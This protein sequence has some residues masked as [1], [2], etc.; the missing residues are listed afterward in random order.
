VLNP[1]N[2]D[3]GVPSIQGQKEDMRPVE[4]LV[5]WQTISS[6]KSRC[7]LIGLY[8]DIGRDQTLGFRL[9]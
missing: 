2:L 3:Q 5:D 4:M 1:L 8:A 7:T 9:K 6:K